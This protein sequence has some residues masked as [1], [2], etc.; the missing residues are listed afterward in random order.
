MAARIGIDTEDDNDFFFVDFDAFDQG[1]NDIAFG[2]E[3]DSAQSIVDRS[4]KFFE[5]IDD[6]KQFELTGF[7]SPRFFDL[8]LDLL[9][10]D[11][12][13]LDLRIEITFVDNPF[14]VAIDES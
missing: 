13:L 14:S 5:A 3:V 12:E 8:M 11:F 7:V 1:T 9:Q 2:R 4:C 10:P 6:Q